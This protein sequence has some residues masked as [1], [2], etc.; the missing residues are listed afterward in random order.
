MTG[1]C[2]CREGYA[3]DRCD[4]CRP[5]WY[6]YP[7]CRPCECSAQVPDV[8]VSYALSLLSHE[9]DLKSFDKFTELGLTKGRGWF[10]NFLGAPM[11]L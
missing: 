4:K 1:S 10:L 3:G 7:N 5:G 9:I 6:G 8:V 11:I 2:I